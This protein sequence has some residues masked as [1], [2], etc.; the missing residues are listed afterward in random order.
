MM[1]NI[2]LF[3]F[4]S[5]FS[6][7]FFSAAVFFVGPGAVFAESVYE[8]TGW[9]WGADDNSIQG[10]CTSPC[11]DLG[12]LGW[13]SFSN[14]TDMTAIPYGVFID[15][16]TGDF[17]GYAWSPNIGWIAFS[18]FDMKKCSSNPGDSCIVPSPKANVNII[19]DP[20]TGAITGGTGI[21]TG[22]AR[23]CSV[24]VSACSGAIRPDLER[25]GWDGWISLQGISSPPSRQPYGLRLNMVGLATTTLKFQGPI[26]TGVFAGT[27]LCASCY[28][29]GGSFSGA[30]G[31]GWGI[32]VGGLKVS[33]VNNILP[34]LLSFWADET[35]LVSGQTTNL[36]WVTS[37]N[38]TSCNATSTPFD[39]DWSGMK[40]P[41]SQVQ[42]QPIGPLTSSEEYTLQC[43]GPSGTTPLRTVN[44]TLTSSVSVNGA[45]GSAAGVLSRLMPE[46]NLCSAGTAGSVKQKGSD[47]EWTCN[48]TNGGDSAD[49]TAPMKRSFQFIQF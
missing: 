2:K 44:I 21:V 9:G 45:C 30:S 12:G 25:G 38:V 37:S 14:K 46:T 49:C 28:A 19:T 43:T 6:L 5:F 31:F 18:A 15:G 27:T 13:V 29:W 35:T 8:V 39:S 24:F 1:H 4:R 22:W 42:F 33:L 7:L 3:S 32:N 41:S 16:T 11:A 10:F 17:S 47:W 34:P 48:G 20:T 36:Y 40:L 26:N 23:A